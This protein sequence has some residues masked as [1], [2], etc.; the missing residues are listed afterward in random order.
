MS[1][2]AD[3]G[4]TIRPRLVQ[5]RDAL[6]EALASATD[7]PHFARSAL[8]RV[9][10]RLG[11]F[12]AALATLRDFVVADAPYPEDIH[13][14]RSAAY[15][16]LGQRG[17]AEAELAHLRAMVAADDSRSDARRF[18]REIELHWMRLPGK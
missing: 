6:V 1:L 7:H 5:Y 9:Q 13:F 17:A 12:A 8:A 15:F 4:A 16:A 11:D 3:G 14:V 18:L 10:L 2:A